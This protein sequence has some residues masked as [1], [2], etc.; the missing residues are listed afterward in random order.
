MRRRGGAETP[1]WTFA[2]SFLWLGDFNAQ[3]AAEYEN[4]KSLYKLDLL[5]QS[6]ISSIL[7][8]YLAASRVS[9]KGAK[10]ASFWS[11]RRIKGGLSLYKV[12][13]PPD[14]R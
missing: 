7:E 13:A 14:R 11:D 9:S 4:T 8:L 10:K 6:I 2:K 12:C 5:N 3:V 1:L